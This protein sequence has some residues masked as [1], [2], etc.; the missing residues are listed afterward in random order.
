MASAVRTRTLIASATPSPSD[1]ARSESSRAVS[2][3]DIRHDCGLRYP[4]GVNL[5]TDLG[6]ITAAHDL[7]RRLDEGSLSTPIHLP[8]GTT[9]F[10]WRGRAEA[11]ELR[12]W[13]PNFPAVPGF[14]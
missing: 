5:V 13:M 2:S 8:D 10:V 12:T 11:A 14:R 6:V 7:E 3:I 4:P 9:M 1:P